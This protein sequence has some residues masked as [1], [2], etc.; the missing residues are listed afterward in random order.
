MKT[1]NERMFKTLS[2]TS[3]INVMGGSF[4][5]PEK[6]YDEKNYFEQHGIYQI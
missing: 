5:G 1:I 6:E 3:L 4:C 2:K